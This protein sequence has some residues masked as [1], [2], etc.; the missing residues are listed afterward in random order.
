MWGAAAPR[1]LP[2]HL[3]RGHHRCVHET[4]YVPDGPLARDTQHVD[5][6]PRFGRFR[7]TAELG[8]GAMGTVYR[9]HD[10]VLGRE[11]AIKTLRVVHDPTILERFFREARTVGAIA[12]PNILAIYDVGQAGEPTRVEKARSRTASPDGAP[13]LVMELAAQG[14]L[15]A[16]L[17]RGPLPADEVRQ[18]GIQIAQAL[19]AAHAANVIHRDVK[20][21]NIL[22]SNGVWKLA[23]FGIARVPNSTLTI[24]GQFLGS[25]WYAAP[26]SLRGGVFAPASDVYGLGA[27]LYEA[28]TGKP[29]HGGDDVG[30]LLARLDDEPPPTPGV[31]A[32]IANAISAALAR[33]P[34]RRPSAE[35]LAHMLAPAAAPRRRWTA[36][37][38]AIVAGLVAAALIAVA[39]GTRSSSAPAAAMSP[40]PSREPD[41]PSAT[42]DR[43]AP[44][45]DDREQSTEPSAD[46]DRRDDDRAL[47]D[48]RDE[49]P[50][51]PRDRDDRPPDPRDHD[52]PPPGPPGPRGKA[53]G[54]HKHH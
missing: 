53:H 1:A 48:P 38:I 43:R 47:D 40:I 4:E 39:V 35:Q 32:P 12:H 21:A 28:A 50:R 41:S 20:P 37:R 31:P 44:S 6:L 24:E 9:A 34:A 2:A 10:D 45:A 46:D 42:E 17:A 36:K 11:V 54:K 19:A 30:A 3:R 15:R 23:D 7:C 18:L 22:A 25:P 52:D 27:T 49:R 8:A 26:E 13:Y 29:P 16:R 33:D 14:S 51:D 5:D